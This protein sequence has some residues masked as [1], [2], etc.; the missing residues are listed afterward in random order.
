MRANRGL[1]RLPTQTP[2][3]YSGHA[4]PPPAE[5][6]RTRTWLNLTPDRQTAYRRHLQALRAI[7]SGALNG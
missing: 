2:E 3:Q 1:V 4:V 6:R 5:L 7:V